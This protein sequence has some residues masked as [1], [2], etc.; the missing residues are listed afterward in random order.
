MKLTDLKK[1]QRGKII[2]INLTENAVKRLTSLGFCQGHEVKFERKAPLS[3]PYQY[4][5]S[6]NFIAL[7]KEDASKIEIELVEDEN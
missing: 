3:D 5:V 7:R 6:G 2:K 1:G 4:Y